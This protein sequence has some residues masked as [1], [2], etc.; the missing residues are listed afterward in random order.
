MFL[1]KDYTPKNLRDEF[2][3]DLE[4][5]RRFAVSKNINYYIVKIENKW[6]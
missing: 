5:R 4:L 1:R 2:I 6:E 3:L